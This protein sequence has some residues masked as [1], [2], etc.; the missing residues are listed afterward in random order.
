MKDLKV[1]DSSNANYVQNKEEKKRITNVCLQA[2]TQGMHV[3][4]ENKEPIETQN[5]LD[6]KNIYNIFYIRILYAIIFFIV[7]VFIQCYFIILSDGY[8][9]T[10]DTPLK[11]RLH[12]LYKRPYFMSQ[13]FVNTCILSLMGISFLR[14]GLFSPTLLAI[15]MFIR[16]AIILGSIYSIRSIFIYVTT[17]PCPVPTCQPLVNNGFLQNIYSIYLIVF[18][19]VYECTDLIISGHT[20]FTTLFVFTWLYYEKNLFIKLIILL[21]SIYLYL[22]IIISRFHYTVDVLLGIFFGSTIFIFYHWLV[23]IAAKRYALNKSFC[24]KR[25]GFKGSFSDRSIVL[26]YLIRII[27][28]MEGLDHRL[29]IAMYYDKEL[30]AFCPCKP[31][32]SQGLIIKNNSGAMENYTFSEHFYHSYAGNGSFDLSTIK[33]FIRKFK[34][35]TG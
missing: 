29:N 4:I 33:Y 9:N 8:Y 21:Y 15:T 13:E 23:D 20:C 24:C 26:N 32:N 35:L 27:A 5:V 28:Y 3:D 22:L 11:D 30:S 12:E 6:K 17:I 16:I 7:G 10:G 19:K 18:A 2:S 34:L 31:V 1:I 14:F 25:P